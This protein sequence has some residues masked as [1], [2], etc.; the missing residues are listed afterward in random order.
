[1]QRLMFDFR[2]TAT[3]AHIL[4]TLFEAM[5]DTAREHYEDMMAHTEV[6]EKHHHTVREVYE[7]VDALLVPE[8]VK[9][10]L[11]AVYGLL[12]A[13]EAEVHGC[14]IEHTHFHEVGNASG[15]RNALAIVVAFYVV[16]PVEV[17]ATPVQPGKGEVECAHGILPLPAPATAVLL[18]DIPLTQ[19]RL[20]GE[21]C[22]P[23]SA[24]LIKHFVTS[25]DAT[26]FER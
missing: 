21:R 8:K 26:L 14:S 17:V 10:D 18:H 5:D 24:A 1:M 19:T 11:H 12:A 13:A 15:I 4:D 20:L 7:T 9:E 3:R 16:A 22:T 2:E 23:T 25:F 6:P